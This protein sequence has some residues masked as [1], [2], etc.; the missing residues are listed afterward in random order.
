MAEGRSDLLHFGP[1]ELDQRS[2]ELRREGERLKLQGQPIELLALLASRSGEV[3]T[4]EEIRDRVWGSGTFVD[5]DQGI[6]ACVRQIRAAL[7]DSHETPR[8]IQTLPRRGYRFLAPVRSSPP[9][10]EPASTLRRPLPAS[11]LAAGVATPRRAAP[12]RLFVVAAAGLVLAMTLTLVG[13]NGPLPAGA[14]AARPVLAVL[15]Y[16]NLSGDS[17]QDYLA[18]GLTEELIAQISRRYGRRLGVIARTTSMSYRGST[19]SAREIAARVKADYV[20]EGS[21]RREGDRVRVTS[22]LVRASDEVHIWSASHDRVTGEFLPLQI[23]LSRQIAGALALQILPEGVR[24][25]AAAAPGAYDAYL[26]AR[27]HLRPPSPKPREAL[28]EL[29]R[30]VAL[31]PGFARAWI[32]LARVR[33]QASNGDAEAL[34]DAREAA[35]KALMLDDALPEAH[36]FLADVA[37][38]HDWDVEAARREWERALELDPGSAELRHALAAYWS[39]TG[40]HDEALRL[41]AESERLDPLAPAVVSDVG[42][43]AYFARRYDAAIE[44]SRRTLE[45]APSYY[46]ARRCILLAAISKGD[47]R[48]AVAAGRAEMESR[49]ASPEQVAA[50][51]APDPREALTAYW[52]WDLTA[53]Q[54]ALAKGTVTHAELAIAHL[55]VGDREAALEALD[56]AVTE[57]RGWILPF[58]NVDPYFDPLRDDPR[59][60]AIL[61]RIGIP[62]PVAGESK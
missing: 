15:P 9:A 58:L 46:W 22:Q 11:V 48:A 26:R 27:G 8:F 44:G 2:G 36:A 18:D 31:D 40:R 51:G 25:A 21:L 34:R 50:L 52:R 42:W 23:D 43:Y 60:A 14:P 33:R 39:A 7:G 55:G 38:Y 19:L 45:H 29:E 6:N 57:R 17:S 62:S 20:L 41:M 28:R 49:Q 53:T 10:E 37:F 4:R 13:W 16:A 47:A 54:A 59:F 35:R 5:F 56:D 1:F 61:E 24:E 12:G 30:A 3:V 32:A